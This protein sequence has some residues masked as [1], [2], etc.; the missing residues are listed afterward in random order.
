MAKDETE[1]FENDRQT[2]EAWFE[3]LS[4]IHSRKHAR[5]KRIIAGLK[6]RNIEQLK[7]NEIIKIKN[8]TA[9]LLGRK[10]PKKYSEE[11]I[12][13]L[14]NAI[15]KLE[16]LRIKRDTLADHNKD[17][18]ATNER[19]QKIVKSLKTIQNNFAMILDQV[20]VVS[21]R[22][23]ILTPFKQAQLE[24]QIAKNMRKEEEKD[25]TEKIVIR[26]NKSKVNEARS[27]AD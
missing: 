1:S 11:A 19:E 10:E 15:R 4:L 18:H 16:Q 27:I 5:Q 24:L 26:T 6:A 25:A 20:N 14:A 23:E 12:F 17:L 3:K 9:Q 21:R 8:E 7:K 2:L 13:E 22:N